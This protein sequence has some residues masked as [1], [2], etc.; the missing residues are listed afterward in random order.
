MLN[1]K[2]YIDNPS[3]LIGLNVLY[4]S[5]Y[6]T[7]IAKIGKVTKR[8]FNLVGDTVNFR[9]TDGA[10]VVGSGRQ[11]WGTGGTCK[12]ITQDE[13]DNFRRIFKEKKQ[14]ELWRDEIKKQ[15]PLLDYT[16][17]EKIISLLPKK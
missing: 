11:N 13:F 1:Y 2:D 8:H 4:I 6:T 16:T 14:S 12:L 10:E 15:L 9:I 5:R 17:L 7:K 3:G